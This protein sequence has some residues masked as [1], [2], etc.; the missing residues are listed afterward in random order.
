MSIETSKS[1]SLFEIRRRG[2]F[3]ISSPRFMSLLRSF[4][5]RTM[6]GCGYYRHAAPTEL[7]IS[8]SQVVVEERPKPAAGKAGIALR[9]AVGHHWPGIGEPGHWIYGA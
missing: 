3:L 9:F 1:K 7:E 8:G 2:M 4:K 5:K 6:L